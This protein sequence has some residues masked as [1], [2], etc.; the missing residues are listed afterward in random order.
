MP[1][2]I[3]SARFGPVLDRLG[4]VL[5]AE[6]EAAADGPLPDAA[7]DLVHVHLE[8]ARPARTAEAGPL[9]DTEVRSLLGVPT[10][11]THQARALD[12]VL[13]GRSVVLATGTASGKSLVAQAAI[14]TACAG[15]RPATAL[16][17]HPTK[18]LG[19]DQLRALDA[20]GL[21]GVVAAA[22]D[23]DSTDVERQW[24]RRHANVI[25]TN[26]DMLH[27]GILP[28]HGQ[29][30]TFL[31]RL[32]Y[33]VVDETHTLRGIFGGHVAHVLRR[34]RRLCDQVGADPTFVFASATVADAAELCHR[35]SGLDVEVVDDDGSPRGERLVAIVNPPLLDPETGARLSSHRVTAHAAA[36][37]VAAGHR[38]IVFCRSRHATETVT[39]AMRRLLPESLHDSVQPYRAGYLVAERR[40]IEAELAGGRLLGVVATSA[41]E[42]GIDIGGLDACV[43]HGFPGTIASFRQQIGRVGR[44]LDPSVAIL[45][46]GHDQLDQYLSTHPDELFERGVEPVVVNPSNPFVLDP[47]LGC[48]AAE[49][50][51]VPADERYWADDLDDGIRRLVID[52]QLRIQQVTSVDGAVEP[53]AVWTGHGHPAGQ[54]GLRSGSGRELRIVDAQRTVIGTVDAARA[55]TS[56]YPG[57]TYLHR[58]EPFRVVELDLDEAI[59]VVEPDDGTTTTRANATTDLEVLGADEV[60]PVGG[61]ELT[62]GPVAVR[63]TVTGYE[64]LDLA[65][66]EVVDRV[67]LTL[68]PSTLVTRAIWYTVPPSV[69]AT[70][71]LDPEQLPGSL[72]ALEHAAI[73]M[74][75]LFA[76]CDRW[77][78][79]GIST[80]WH[81]GT[82]HATVAIYDGYPGGAGIAE[83][84]WSE[85]DRH[86][87]TTLEMVRACPCRTGCPSCVQS[88]K[89]GNGN[90]PLDKA[91]A[92]ALA[93]AA[94]APT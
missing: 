5:R 75:P 55:L 71:G 15:P 61:L 94:L 45:V 18:A 6:A 90:D 11:W 3:A 34:L 57:A 2:P 23:G 26:P 86:L 73:A 88:P 53:R 54:V 42:L 92:I 93:A 9:L 16:L 4:A 19:H 72:H 84:G 63:H 85:A 56:L 39:T 17:L 47:Q 67:E 74:L 36:S 43:V 41:L 24:V 80:P 89:C 58:T 8:P 22:Y 32:Q 31:R 79:G 27:V 37:L 21:P 60:R 40:A 44:A 81:A 46:A 12:H 91:G 28:R 20:L 14:G 35:L 30:A 87:V 33:V 25:C 29:W 76:I 70:A 78:V 62:L 7:A 65:T 49:A 48:A 68:P 10:L 64:R 66:G 82:G 77:D 50:P 13:V 38:T 52:D 51:L 69:T 1:D 83:L 59:A